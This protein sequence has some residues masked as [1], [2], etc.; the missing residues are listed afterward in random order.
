ML[1]DAIFA[2]AAA[3]LRLMLLLPRRRRRYAAAITLRY[4]AS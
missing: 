2:D 1:T 4:F 3:R